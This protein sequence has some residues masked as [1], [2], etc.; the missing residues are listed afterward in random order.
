MMKQFF[1][2]CPNALVGSQFSLKK[3]RKPPEQVIQRKV[4]NLITSLAMAASTASA[5]NPTCLKDRSV[6]FYSINFSIDLLA[7]DFT[8][9]VMPRNTRRLKERAIVN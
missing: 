8:I 9:C 6:I 3:K 1:S 7:D 4:C 5:G 2:L